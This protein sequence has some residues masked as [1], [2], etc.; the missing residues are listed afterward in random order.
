[1]VGV[2]RTTRAPMCKSKSSTAVSDPSSS[3]ARSATTNTTTTRRR[4]SPTA[5]TNPTSYSTTSGH[6]TTSS[7]AASSLQAL[8]DSL[9]P[10]LPLLLTFH[11][12]AAATASFSAAHRLV[13]TSSNSF[14]CTLRGRPSAVFRRALRRDPREVASRLAALG[15]CH[16][17]AIARLYGCS[18]DDSSGAGGGGGGSLF[19]A[20]ELVPSAAP[21]SALLRPGNPAAGYTPLGTWRAR[22]RVAADVCDAISYVHGQ[23]GTVHNRLAA[24]SVLV[25]AD[26]PTAVRAKIAH[27]GA[28]DLAGELPPEDDDGVTTRHRSRRIEGKRGYMAPELTAGTSPPTRRSDVFAV[29]VLLLEL[30]SGQE[31]ARYELNEATGEYERTS[32]IETAEEAMGDPGTRMRRWVDRRLGDSFP[33]EAAEALAGVALRCVARDPAARPEMPWVAAKVSKLFLEAQ[34]WADKFLVPTGISVS[35]A[36]R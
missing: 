24:S 32:L 14:R 13:P 19:L 29:G 16:H 5:V 23:A 21:L 17:A 2:R 1:M 31:P 28:A 9:L 26:G 7:S 22:L 3:M 20:Y 36:P 33:V 15:H 18:A 12:L 35:I 25:V 4:T 30:V 8:K 27:F 6:S 34:D 10:D 11:E